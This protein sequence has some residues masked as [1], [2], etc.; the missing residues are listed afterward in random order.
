MRYAGFL[1]Q[2]LSI[3]SDVEASKLT[4]CFWFSE[5]AECVLQIW[6]DHDQN[7]PLRWE[8]S[9]ETTQS[10][11]VSSPMWTLL[12]M[13]DEAIHDLGATCCY[14]T[15]RSR[16]LSQQSIPTAERGTGGPSAVRDA[17][18]RGNE[19]QG[20]MHRL[21]EPGPRTRRTEVIALFV[22]HPTICLACLRKITHKQSS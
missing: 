2:T 5:K 20:E 10:K 7:N 19:Q 13:A 16:D 1:C 15:R 22:V 14:W 21:P 18:L 3:Y 11:S 4:K 9:G 6:H 8:Q 17:Y 12:W